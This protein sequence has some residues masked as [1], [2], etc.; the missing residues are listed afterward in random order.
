MRPDLASREL[1]A[2]LAFA[3]PA[4]QND[5]RPL[6]SWMQEV[7][8]S[9]RRASLQPLGLH[10][11][12]RDTLVAGGSPK[13]AAEALAFHLDKLRQCL[14]AVAASAARALDAG[15]RPVREAP[16]EAWLND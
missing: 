8:Q 10:P 13:P 14:R 3:D 12:R 15:P 6:P 5:L 9:A 7:Q 2:R 1:L 4:L 16:D 11:E